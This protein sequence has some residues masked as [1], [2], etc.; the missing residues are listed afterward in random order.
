MGK[1]KEIVRD[2]QLDVQSNRPTEDHYEAL[3][4][5]YRGFATNQMSLMEAKIK[6]D[7]DGKCDLLLVYNQY[8]AQTKK[9][10]S[11][12]VAKL[13]LHG[14]SDKYVAPDGHGGWLKR[15]NLNDNSTA[16]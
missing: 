13:L 16:G 15:P 9:I 12:P 6:D 8:D 5:F 7:P 11:V 3:K 14:D 2:V 4:Q 10:L 1:K